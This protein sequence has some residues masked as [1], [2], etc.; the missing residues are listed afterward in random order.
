MAMIRAEVIPARALC[1]IKFDVSG[2]TKS[3]RSS[4]SFEII[5]ISGYIGIRAREVSW[6]M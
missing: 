5:V 4:R 6:H 3:H 1:C 2:S